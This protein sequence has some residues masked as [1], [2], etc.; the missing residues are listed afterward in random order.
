LKALELILKP[1]D[2]FSDG[3]DME[4]LFSEG[5]NWVLNWR[6]SEAFFLKK[7]FRIKEFSFGKFSFGFKLSVLAFECFVLEL[8]LFGL[9]KSLVKSLGM[10]FLKIGDFF[11]MVVFNFFEFLPLGKSDF[12]H[13]LFQWRLLI[14]KFFD[15][16]PEGIFPWSWI[17]FDRFELLFLAWV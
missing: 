14:L 6:K 10:S 13:F 8:D 2:F 5:E 4:V 15:S 9:M 7:F 17:L 16:L 1:S 12:G 3:L 11:G